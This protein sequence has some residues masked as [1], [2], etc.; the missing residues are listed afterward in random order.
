MIGVGIR[1]LYSY[2]DGLDYYYYCKKKLF[3]KYWP[4]FE[5]FSNFFQTEPAPAAAGFT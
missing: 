3:L 5:N 4:C 1:M 2:S